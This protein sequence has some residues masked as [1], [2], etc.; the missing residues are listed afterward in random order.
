MQLLK[1]KT[2]RLQY[3]YNRVTDI[4]KKLQNGY[5]TDLLLNC[6]KSAQD[7][8][9]QDLALI[10]LHFMIWDHGDPTNKRLSVLGI[11]SKAFYASC[12]YLIHEEFIG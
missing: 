11:Q 6:K 4:C 9:M 10:F 3:G 7:P 2:K 1:S 5:N 8:Y 12:K